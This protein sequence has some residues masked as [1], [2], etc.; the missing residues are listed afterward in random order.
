VIDFKVIE[1]MKQNAGDYRTDNVI[2]VLLT[3]LNDSRWV[4]SLVY[5]GIDLFDDDI[6]LETK[7]V[8]VPPEAVKALED[9]AF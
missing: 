2:E 7:F 3:N 9:A 5:N 1:F 8:T 6:L 4:V